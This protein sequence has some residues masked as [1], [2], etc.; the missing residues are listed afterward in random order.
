MKRLI[1]FIQMIWCIVVTTIRFTIALII[2]PL[3]M[4]KIFFFSK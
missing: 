2:V 4:A 3:F 1:L